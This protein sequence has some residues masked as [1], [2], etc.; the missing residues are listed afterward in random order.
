MTSFP[1]ALC[2]AQRARLYVWKC[3]IHH[4]HHPASAHVCFCVLVASL[5]H[6]SLLH[7]LPHCLMDKLRDD[8]ACIFFQRR[9]AG[10]ATLPLS[11]ALLAA[12]SCWHCATLIFRVSPP[13]TCLSYWLSAT[14]V[15]LFSLLVLLFCLCHAS[16]GRNSEDATSPSQAPL[17]FGT[18]FVGNFG[19]KTQLLSFIMT[20]AILL[21][22]RYCIFILAFRSFL[23]LSSLVFPQLLTICSFV[24]C[25]SF[26]SSHH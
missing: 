9:K 24:S 12:S 15:S 22:P 11:R 5:P 10:W 25:V 8:A 20:L 7:D 2:K 23:L 13:Y 19:V 18:V 16:D 14:R 6:L 17:S 1:T 3:A 26:V 21:N 4:H